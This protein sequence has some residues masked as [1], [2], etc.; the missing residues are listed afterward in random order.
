M[1]SFAFLYLYV[2]QK[3]L[4]VPET[5]AGDR[6]ASAVGLNEETVPTDIQTWEF[7]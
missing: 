1:R 7:G 5:S 2:L 4:R 3:E 6:R